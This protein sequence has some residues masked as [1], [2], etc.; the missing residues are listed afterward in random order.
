MDLDSD[1]LSGNAGNLDSDPSIKANGTLTLSMN[2]TPSIT[3]ASAVICVMRAVISKPRPRRFRKCKSFVGAF[4][5]QEAVGS[6]S[7][8]PFNFFCTIRI[9]KIAFNAFMD[10]ICVCASSIA[11]VRS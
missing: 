2:L 6:P 8:T 7:F 4:R 3:L 10:I 11:S 5:P 1:W 9:V